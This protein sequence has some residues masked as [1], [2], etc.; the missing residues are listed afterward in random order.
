M[1]SG[2]VADR[3]HARGSNPSDQRELGSHP[4]ISHSGPIP[5]LIGSGATFSCAASDSY[6][7]TIMPPRLGRWDFLVELDRQVDAH[8]AAALC[9]A[10]T[11]DHSSF[12]NRVLL[13]GTQNRTN[14]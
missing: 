4:R 1:G 6:N 9:R 5:S 12:I 10:Q 8:Q 11:F 3:L 7:L 14:R 2:Q 13:L